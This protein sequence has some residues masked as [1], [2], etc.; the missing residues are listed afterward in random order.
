MQS[1]LIAEKEQEL[2]LKEKEIKN[3]SIRS[4]SCGKQNQG[5][6]QTWGHP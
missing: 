5:L 3:A 2:M 1:L 4:S 6:N